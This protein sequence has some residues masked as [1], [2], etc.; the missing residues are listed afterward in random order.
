MS[1]ANINSLLVGRSVLAT[2]CIKQ[3]KK[4]SARQM[5][6]PIAFKRES[7]GFSWQYRRIALH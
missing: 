3:E 6:V 7:D 1:W 4:Q 2:S 5:A